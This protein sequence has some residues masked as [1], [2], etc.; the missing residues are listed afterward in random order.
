MVAESEGICEECGKEAILGDGLCA[1]CW[2]GPGDKRAFK[3][4]RDEEIFKAVEKSWQKPREIFRAK[5]WRN[6]EK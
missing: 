5:H 2:D 1:K 4:N 6:S 3:N